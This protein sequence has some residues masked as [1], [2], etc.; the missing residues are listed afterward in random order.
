[1]DNP[2]QWHM[3]PHRSRGRNN[4]HRSGWSQV[5][6]CRSSEFWSGDVQ[7]YQQHI[8]IRSRQPGPSKTQSRRCQ[9]MRN[10]N[11]LKNH[12]WT[13][14]ERLHNARASPPPILIRRSLEKQFRGFTL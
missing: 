9:N 11:G 4:N 5:Q 8:R 13:N 14:R 6:V 2:L 1:M 7:M 3:M 12:Y 10:K